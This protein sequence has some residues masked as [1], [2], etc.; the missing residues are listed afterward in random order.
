MVQFTWLDWFWLVAF[1][2]AML[3]SGALFYRLGK[4]SESDFF[5]A[6]RKLPWWLPASELGWF[7]SLIIVP[8]SFTIAITRYQLWNIDLVINR[9][10]VY[11]ALT[12]TLVVIYFI[13]I[14]LLYDSIASSILPL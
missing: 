4:R 3:F 7:L 10:L 13:S 1:L 2:L 11:G 5:L 8:L 12:G 14:A 6:D 9:T